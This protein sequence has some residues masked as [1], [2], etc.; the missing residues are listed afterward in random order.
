MKYIKEFEGLRGALAVWVLLGHWASSVD[1]DIWLF[2]QKLLNQHAV[3]VFIILSGFAVA[4]MIDK[5]PEP[6]VAYI[7]RRFLRIFPVYLLFLMLSV[8]A[9][10]LALEVWNQAPEG[11]MKSSRIRIAQ[12]SLDDWMA[13]LALHLPAL[14]GLMPAKLLP[15]S[16]YAFLGQAWSISL[17]WQFYLVAPFLI[18]LLWVRWT[19]GKC[20]TAF[21][22]AII[23]MGANAVMTPA[24]LG[25]WLPEFTIGIGT[26]YLLRDQSVGKGP[27]RSF[28]V[29]PVCLLT[30]LLALFWSYRDALPFIIWSICV[31]A[32][33]GGD[34]NSRNIIQKVLLA[35]SLQ[36]VGK[37]AYSVYLSHML[38]LVVAI[39]FLR[40]LGVFD[41]W[42]WAIST[43]GLMLVGTWGLSKLS[44][45]FVEKPFHELG[46]RLDVS[47]TS[48]KA[49]TRV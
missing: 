45:L 1:V 29:L 30:C 33:A 22:C 36:S 26:Y 6:Y 44:Y 42:L 3:T 28:P 34:A 23:I 13:H 17:E 40:S 27:L 5:R 4:G 24:F 14:H 15:S 43:L 41:G 35:P 49:S 9:T 18:S 19:I 37:M 38:V 2:E 32:V 11:A 39:Y 8:L 7:S 31:A 21:A 12:N 25:K 16:A 10:P 46:R 47:P 20:I 48:L